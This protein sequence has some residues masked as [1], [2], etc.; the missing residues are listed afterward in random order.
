MTSFA[1]IEANRPIKWPRPS[2]QIDFSNIS[3][4]IKMTNRRLKEKEV[5]EERE[6]VC[7]GEEI[8]VSCFIQREDDFLPSIHNFNKG[9]IEKENNTHKK[10]IYN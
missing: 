8:K 9:K 7:V 6:R 5:Y 2:M 4:N 10:A 1:T 3:N